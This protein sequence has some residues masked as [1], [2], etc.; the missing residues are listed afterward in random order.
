[1]R[2][3]QSINM[4]IH[5]QTNNSNWIDRSPTARVA[6]VFHVKIVETEQ[7]SQQLRALPSHRV[8]QD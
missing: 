3:L 7:L 1:M 5:T 8:A 4:D 6:L 2:A